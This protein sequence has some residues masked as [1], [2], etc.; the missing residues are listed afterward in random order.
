MKKIKNFFKEKKA[1]FICAGIVS[2]VFCIYLL[3]GGIWP[4]GT[5]TFAKYDGYFQVVQFMGYMFDMLDGNATFA[6][7]NLVGGGANMVGVLLYFFLN[8]FAFVALLMGR[9]N[10]YFSINIM[11]LFYFVVISITFMYFLRKKFPE[12]KTST[13]ILL[14]CLYTFCAYTLCNQTIMVWLNFLVILPLLWLEFENVLNN[15]KIWKFSLLTAACIYTSYAV[16]SSLQIVLLLVYF[17]YIFIATPKENRKAA[18]LNTLVGL[19]CGLLLSLIV[20]VPSL[21]QLKTSC[22]TGSNMNTLFNYSNISFNESAI[23]MGIFFNLLN[24]SLLLI[25]VW[26]LSKTFKTSKISKF[27]AFA[28]ILCNLPI[29]FND[30]SQFLAGGSYICFETRFFSINSFLMFFALAHAFHYYSI[31]P[32]SIENDQNVKNSKI[33]YIIVA[34]FSLIFAV[35]TAINFMALG[36]ILA[37]G[38]IQPDVLINYVLAPL[39]ILSLLILCFVFYKTKLINKKLLSTL[40]IILVCVESF[41]SGMCVLS[42]SAYSTQQSSVYY[43]LTSTLSP[44][45]RVKAEIDYIGSNGNLISGVSTYSIFSSASAQNTYNLIK[46]LGYNPRVPDIP[47]RNGTLLSDLLLGYEYIVSD[48]DL[49]DRNYLTLISSE[50]G[51]SLYKID[52]AFPKAFV[53]DEV[54][55]PEITSD[56]NVISAQNDLARML[57]ATSD[58]MSASTNFTMEKLEKEDPDSNV[59]EYT[60]SFTAEKNGVVYLNN[61]QIKDLTVYN[62]NNENCGTTKQNDLIDIGM[63]TQGQTYTIIVELNEKQEINQEHIELDYLITN[64]LANIAS[65][66]QSRKVEINYQKN[67]YTLDASHITNKN[68][69]LIQSNPNGM[70]YYSNIENSQ[71]AASTQLFDLTYFENVNQEIITAKFEYPHTKIVLLTGIGGIIAAITI[72]ILF[73][74]KRH[75]FNFLEPFGKV[76]YIVIASAVTFYFYVFAGFISII[77]IISLI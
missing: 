6:F 52:W 17:L 14:S 16:G 24:S 61:L 50:N 33:I 63:V 43:N 69:L 53:M 49:S 46:Y 71:F 68:I 20:L 77:K 7:S 56:F 62:V 41:A 66:L 12:L 31:T 39:T 1:Y 45:T 21:V 51:I 8:P 36:G 32:S 13:K 40:A 76:A 55:S 57:G 22:R 64:E 48:K 74:K 2:A 3:I 42:T 10:L 60:I 19:L 54:Y 30:I 70:Q 28:L 58:M 25:I 67:G 38:Q 15:G 4:F 72:L 34:I 44:N 11:Y 75:W 73:T 26:Y 18:C 35:V 27:L 23:P 5:K 9:S 29:F 65:D 47:Q 59:Q 37:I